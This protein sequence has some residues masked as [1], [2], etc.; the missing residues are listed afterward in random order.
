[1]PT[2]PKTFSR[3]EFLLAL[4]GLS[5][6]F[7]PTDSPPKTPEAPNLN[8]KIDKVGWQRLVRQRTRWEFLPDGTNKN[9]LLCPSWSPNV[10][11]GRISSLFDVA[12]NRPVAEFI[13]AQASLQ[14]L[15]IRTNIIFDEGWGQKEGGEGHQAAFTALIPGINEQF[16]ILWLKFAAWNAIENIKANNLPLEPYF[17]GFASYY[18]SEWAVH[19]AAHAGAERKAFGPRLIPPNLEAHLHK[20]IFDFQRQYTELFKE[21]EK[22]RLAENAL[23]FALSPRLPV[24]QIRDLLVQEAKVYVK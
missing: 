11:M 1:M 24:A 12:V 6:S 3:C 22:E 14:S 20:Q 9:N 18:L 23:V 16:T 13:F 2:R 4:A 10:C 7:L 17:E 21:A 8:L 15:P 19:E 5:L